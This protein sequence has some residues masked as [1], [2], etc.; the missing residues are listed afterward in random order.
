MFVRSLFP[1]LLAGCSTYLPGVERDPAGLAQSLV[2]S[3][4]ADPIPAGGG[5]VT[6]WA[7]G[8]VAGDVVKFYTA[9]K[10]G[11]GP[12]YVKLGGLCLDV[13]KPKLLGKATADAAG[14]AELLGVFPG[15]LVAGQVVYLQVAVARGPGGVDSVLSPVASVIVGAVDADGDG[16]DSSTDCDDADP[17]VFPGALERCN[18]VDDDCDAATSEDGLVTVEVT[19]Y[20]TIGEA[21]LHSPPGSTVS[22]CAGTY[23]ENLDLDFDVTL[24]GVAGAAETVIDGGGFTVI[25]ANSAANQWIEG[26]TVT[27]GGYGVHVSSLIGAGAFTLKHAVVTGNQT[28]FQYTVTKDSGGTFLLEDVE[29]SDDHGAMVGGGAWIVNGSG[30]FVDVR[31]LDNTAPDGGAL[32]VSAL[33]DTIT[34]E[35]CTLH[36]NVADDHGGA[37]YVEVLSSPIEVVDSDFGVGATE[38][39]PDDVY[40]GNSSNPSYPW[41]QDHE[42]F[43]CYGGCL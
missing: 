39:L 32:Y 6:V 5:P 19:N 12:C 42:T 28:G 4:A 20:S 21:V 40:L 37:V 29:L 17:A 43:T 16:H 25:S 26:F 8:L 24:V 38:N 2:P 34:L 10:L 3:V 33:D 35:R 30:A 36:G 1:W 13:V 41:F 23:V 15:V 11:A 9:T 7:D 31:F 22:V 27:N 18:A 14:H